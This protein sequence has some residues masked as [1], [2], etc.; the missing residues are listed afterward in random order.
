M[1]VHRK[2]AGAQTRA[3]FPVEPV[4]CSWASVGLRSPRLAMRRLV[5]VLPLVTLATAAVAVGQESPEPVTRLPPIRVTAPAPVDVLARPTT[6]SRIDS[7]SMDEVKA[8]KAPVLPDILERL[9]GVSLQNEQGNRFQPDLTLRGFTASPVTGLPQGLSVFLDGVRLNE[10]TVEEVNFDLIPLDDVERIDVIR[11]PSVLFGRNTLGGAINLVTRRG[12]DTREIVPEIAFGSFGRRDYRLRIGGSARPFDYAVSLTEL[13]DDGFR[14]ATESRV[15]RVFAKLGFGL[16]GT[17]ATLSYQYSNDRIKQA[18]SLPEADA[19]RHR[20]RNFTAGD[21]FSPELHQAILNV[22]QTIDEGLSVRLNAF[23][24]A[25]RSEQFNVN[26]LGENTRHFTDTRSTGGTVQGTYRTDVL[27]RSNV[28]VAGVEYVRSD[29]T[30]RTFL[31]VSGQPGIPDSNLADTQDSIGVYAQDSLTVLRDVPIPGSSVVLTVAGRWDRVRH[32][33][34]DRLEDLSDGTH[35][36]QRLNPRA[37]VTVNVSD[38]LV[39]YASYS[40][41]FRAPA[42][43]E[44]TCAGPG[45]VCPGLQAGVAPDPPLSAVTARNYEVG[46]TARPFTW[47]DVDGSVFRT[48]LSDD[49]FAVTPTGT[50]GVFFQNIGRTRREGIEVALRARA[51]ARVEGYLNYTFTRATFQDSAELATPLPPGV[52]TVRPGD[53]LALVPRHRINAGV[54]YHPWRWATLSLDVRYVSSQFLR[55]DEVNRQRPLPD[56]VVVGAGASVRIRKLEVFA[57]VNNLFDERYET[58]GTFAA[59]GRQPGNPVQRFLTPAPPIN[60]LVGA[61]YAF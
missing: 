59:N 48:D 52:Q 3:G 46:V 40:E 42:F 20:H 9:P 4:R 19:Q 57:R 44:L 49:I 16:S 61:Q 11:G 50:T 12:G 2:A 45:A 23:V 32:A 55:G 58:F 18:G 21:F 6:P 13:L 30:S 14:D 15:S 54:A 28:L 41:G 51:A 38:R 35:T 36:F 60:V 53:S 34:E 25:L 47:L 7:V 33:I 27:G 29:V 31:E 17:D 24:R 10:P 43:L 22:E 37:G 5:L 26:F 8:S 56:Y 1:P 39:L